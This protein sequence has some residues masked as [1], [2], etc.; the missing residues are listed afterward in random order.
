[1]RNEQ[2]KFTFIEKMN[3][4]ALERNFSSAQSARLAAAAT[5]YRPPTSRQMESIFDV[6]N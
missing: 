1:M 3:R 5:Q 2:S 4:T 6:G